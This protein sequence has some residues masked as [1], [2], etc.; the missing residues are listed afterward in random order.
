MD[1]SHLLP[2]LVTAGVVYW[3]YENPRTSIG[4]E[5]RTGIVDPATSVAQSLKRDLGHLVDRYYQKHLYPHAYPVVRFVIPADS[6]TTHN[7]E[8]VYLL[9]R[10]PET[11]ELFDYN[12]L[13]Q[14]G[15]HEC[16][17]TLCRSVE[18]GDHGPAFVE[19]LQRLDQIGSEMNLYDSKQPIPNR[20][21]QLC[22]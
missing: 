10:D 3:L 21:K 17:H 14:V 19:V 5:D 22:H 11:Q 8:T 7:H 15:A 1:S 6:S 20:Y 9:I 4:G 2:A 13:L 18:G 12:T 16:A